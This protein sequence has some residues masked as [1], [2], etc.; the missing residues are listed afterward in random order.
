M[1]R[2]IALFIVTWG[3][4]L[5][6]YLGLARV[7][8]ETRGLRRRVDQLAAQ[9]SASTASY[10][11]DLS[12]DVF[13][14]IDILLVAESSCPSC[15]AVLE[16]LIEQASAHQLAL[17]TYEDPT[18]WTPYSNRIQIIRSTT[19]WASIAHLSP[20]VLLRLDRGGR[21]VSDIALPVDES[22]LKA[23]LDLWDGSSKEAID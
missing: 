21:T 13:A 20:P 5:L 11:I 15:W 3:V 7:L 8:Y 1:D 23:T 10:P 12:S 2:T 19:D 6:L 18:V 17:L 4:M 22:D 9:S 14:D 16:C